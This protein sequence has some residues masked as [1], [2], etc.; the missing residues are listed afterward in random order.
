MFLRSH[1]SHELWTYWGFTLSCE[2][3]HD[4]LPCPSNDHFT[5]IS[6]FFFNLRLIC[7]SVEKIPCGLF[8]ALM[9]FSLFVPWFFH[10]ETN[11]VKTSR[12]DLQYTMWCQG[13]DHCNFPWWT[14][15]VQ[16]TEKVPPNCP[17]TSP[18]TDFII[19]MNYPSKTNKHLFSTL[20]I[21]FIFCWG[22]QVKMENGHFMELEIIDEGLREKK[23]ERIIKQCQKD[24]KDTEQISF[25]N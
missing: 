3:Y 4:I 11:E 21:M 18:Q 19:I 10:F 22:C 12:P 5:A 9:S 8:Q 7:V 1:I 6:A 2:F 16:D 25:F 20:Q 17:L 15:F 13:E 23:E 14:I 24:S